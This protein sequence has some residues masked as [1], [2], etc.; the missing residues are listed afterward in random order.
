[1]L[2]IKGIVG[3]EILVYNIFFRVPV[4][5]WLTPSA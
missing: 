3:I 4:T 1:M 5:L 2:T